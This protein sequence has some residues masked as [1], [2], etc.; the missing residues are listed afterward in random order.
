MAAAALQFSMRDPLVDV[1]I[2]GMSKPER[3]QE[4][5]DL[6]T[7]DLPEELWQDLDAVPQFSFDPEVGRY[8][9]K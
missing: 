3:V 2:V 8:D 5:I 1:T 4:T 6:A 9:S 7:I